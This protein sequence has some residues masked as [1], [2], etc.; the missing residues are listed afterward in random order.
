M[1]RKETAANAL[2][3]KLANAAARAGP[4]MEALAKVAGDTPISK[5]DIPHLIATLNDA[6]H[7]APRGGPVTHNTV[8]RALERLRTGV[9]PKRWNI[10]GVSAE[11]IEIM[12]RERC[13][14]P[15]PGRSFDEQR[16]LEAELVLE[17]AKFG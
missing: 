7:L 16:A 1:N 4:L 13:M 11:D 12:R 8:M 14:P 9:I 2:T 15:P 5:L 3:H 6:G 17:L 10:E